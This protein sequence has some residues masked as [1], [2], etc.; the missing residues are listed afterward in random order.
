MINLKKEM[1]IKKDLIISDLDGTL[2]NKSLVLEHY[3]YLINKGIVEDDGSYSAWVN[4]RKNEKL[5]VATAMAYQ[6][7]ITGKRVE[8]L[9]VVNFVTE[10]VADDNNWHLEVM[11]TLEV[12]RDFGN[13]DIVLITGSA[14]FLVQPLCEI[15]GFDSFSTIYTRDLKTGKLDGNVIGMFAEGQKSECIQKNIDL[16]LY[17]EVIGYGDTASDFGIFQ[18]CHKNYLV[19]PTKETLEKLVLKGV[20]IEKIY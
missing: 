19:E 13:T 18:Y 8:D 7:A 1:E 17:S 5:I 10:F 2:T 3:G 16:H 14:D 4:D 12:A 6:K 15:L 20:K 11:E 9:D